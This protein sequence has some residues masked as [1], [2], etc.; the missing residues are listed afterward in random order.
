MVEGVSS[1]GLVFVSQDRP[2]DRPQSAGREIL[3]SEKKPD[4]LSPDHEPPPRNLGTKQAGNKRSQKQ[5]QTMHPP[6]IRIYWQLSHHHCWARQVCAW[7]V[8]VSTT[9]FCRDWNPQGRSG[10]GPNGM[11]NEAGQLRHLEQ[12]RAEAWFSNASDLAYSLAG[13]TR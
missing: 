10:A 2:R 12:E 9:C 7:H 6:M 3:V 8:Y 4:E 11:L 5:P 13:I 1:E